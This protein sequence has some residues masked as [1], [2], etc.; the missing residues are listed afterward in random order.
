MSY[1]IDSELGKQLY[2]LLPEVYRNRDKTTGQTGG[3]SGSED[4]ARYLDVH[5][6]LLDRIHATLQRQLEDSLPKSSQDWLLSYFAQLLAVNIV[7]PDSDGK[8]AE[9]SNAVS[10]RQRKGTLNCVE[11]IAE[12]VGQME[13]EFQ[14]GWKRVAMTPRIGMPLL[15]TRVWDDT[16]VINM[17]V[18]SDAIRHP[19]LPVAMVDLRRAS[20][21]VEA[22]PTNPA[23][24]LSSF[25]GIKQNWRPSNRHGVPCFP[26]SFD[27][28]S[29]RTVDLRTP[30]NAMSSMD[31]TIGHHHH[32]R[33]LAYAPPPAGLFAF[34]KLQLTWAERNDS[35][36]EHLIE[37]K[38]ENGVWIIRNTTARIIEITDDA[39]LEPAR[40]YRVEGLNFKLKLSVEIGGSLELS[41]VEANE[42]QV[43]TPVI[44]E[45]VLRAQ[46]C[47]FGILSVGSGL[48]KLDSCTIVGEAF[49]HTVEALDCIFKT[50]SGTNIAGVIQYSRIPENPPL[51]PSNMTIEDCSTAEP[52]FFQDQD[53]L[54]ASAVLAPNTSK[55][56]YAG[57]SDGSEMGFFHNGRKGKPVH[58]EGHFTGSNLLSMPANDNFVIQDIIFKGSVEVDNGKFELVRSAVKS[59]I[60]KTSL[61]TDDSEVVIPSLYA[62][63]CL[64]DQI[65]VASGLARLEY[66]TV[67]V[68]SVCQQ[69]QASDCIFVGDIS[70]GDENEPKSGC[71]RY[72]RIPEDFDGTT[73]N[74]YPGRTNTNT[75][76]IP[77]F[78][79]IDFCDSEM[80]E[81]QQAVFGE[82]GYGVL[83]PVTSYAIRFGAEDGGEMGACHHKYYSLKTEAMLD[84]M[85][86]FLPVGIKPVL[87]FDTRLL[88]VPPEIKELE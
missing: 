38:E 77:M 86:E 7:S 78:S 50:M 69:L 16:L 66:C 87:I 14:E 46:D 44:D 27:D 29:R 85:R 4:L 53:A 3:N 26:G 71:I 8:H 82:P 88:R 63:E 5:G 76:E 52:V 23:A 54:T 73:L 12:A 42:V 21:A 49:L 34:K 51:S 57:A 74:V 11:Q 75:R 39:N 37:E 17:N 25:A 13:V 35:L 41:K 68:S 61:L 45:V 58:I 22:K 65:E 43:L 1:V 59:L 6:H 64:F 24:R 62:N 36:Y 2:Q 32:K 40:P 28:V 81:R 18:P 47:L 19:S 55:S 33:L 9:V 60:I 79:K 31:N 72:S 56:I 20:R 48:A 15:P 80:P 84:K 30:H 70:D 10:W 83:S 67:M